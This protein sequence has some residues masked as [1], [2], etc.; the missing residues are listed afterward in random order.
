MKH[1]IKMCSLVEAL[2]F[3]RYLNKTSLRDYD[4]RNHAKDHRCYS[5]DGSS[6]VTH[7]GNLISNTAS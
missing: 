5:I 7:R 3:R 2:I 4:S 6:P 1:N